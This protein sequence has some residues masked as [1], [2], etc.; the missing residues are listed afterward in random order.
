MRVARTRLLTIALVSTVL[1]ASVGPSLAATVDVV[2]IVAAGSPVPKLTRA[3]VADIFLG[4]TSRLPD[5]PTVVPLDQPEGSTTRDVFY[6]EFTDKSAA[7]VKAHWSKIIFT[8]R[9]RPPAEVA[10]GA[11]AKRRVK[12]D[13]NAIAYVDRRLVDDSVRIVSP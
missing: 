12:S 10:D 5:G 2:A 9:G 7:Q 6:E 8:G 3:Q 11:E 1:L 4:R 13:R